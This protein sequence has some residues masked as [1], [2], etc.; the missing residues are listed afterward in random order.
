VY[1]A[2]KTKLVQIGVFAGEEVDI[3]QAGG[4]DNRKSRSSV[5]SRDSSCD[6]EIKIRLGKVNAT[7]G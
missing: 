4:G 6:K 5:V 3:I 1:Y 2:G 7:F